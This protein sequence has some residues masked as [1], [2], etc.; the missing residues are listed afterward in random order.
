M[1]NRS[2]FE[3][4]ELSVFGTVTLGGLIDALKPLVLRDGSEPGDGDKDRW[5][6]FDLGGI[7]PCHVGSY[8]GYYDHLAVRYDLG[9]TDAT[10]AEFLKHLEGA[11]GTYFQG[12]KGGEFRMD[13]HTPVWVANAGDAPSTAIVG[14][15]VESLQVTLVTEYVP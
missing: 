6:R 8:R 5:I 2:M 10:V 11:V 13:R 3:G 12:W 1:S 14:L 15:I 9:S 4:A 7:A